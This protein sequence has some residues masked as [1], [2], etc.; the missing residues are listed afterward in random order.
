MENK[1]LKKQ[2]IIFFSTLVLVALSAFLFYRAFWKDAGEKIWLD[3]VY[4]GIGILSLGVGV[5]VSMML[6]SRM[7]FL[8]SWLAGLGIFLILP[9]LNLY[10]LAAL[11]V[12]FLC[13]YF[14]FRLHLIEERT[15]L[16][17]QIFWILSRSLP[18]ILTGIC[19]L[20]AMIYF[21]SPSFGRL[22]LDI[23]IPKPVF[24][25]AW[26]FMSPQ[27]ELQKIGN[28]KTV[29]KQFGIQIPTAKD[30][31]EQTYEKVNAAINLWFE[32]TVGG[33]K[34][35][36][37]SLIVVLGVFISLRTFGIPL[38]WLIIGISWVILKILMKFRVARIE[39]MQVEKEI[40]IL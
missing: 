20:V 25:F 36:Y 30:L 12:F 32:K 37:L 22:N 15:R 39:K 7:Y 17:I 3:W 27:L 5:S 18:T 11:A 31:K 24:E 35:E 9:G 2:W 10:L 13:L 6:L 28:M 1:K 33:Q 34:K 21:L 38:M 40:L 14:G 4:V 19:F 23:S 8:I 26:Q 16:K 29:E